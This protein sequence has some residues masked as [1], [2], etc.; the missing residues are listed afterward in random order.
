[1]KTPTKTKLTINGS[2]LDPQGKGKGGIPI[3]YSSEPAT[4]TQEAKTTS[5][6]KWQILVTD[7]LLLN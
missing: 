4:N 2:L 7:Q 3:K 6:G 1:V 5:D